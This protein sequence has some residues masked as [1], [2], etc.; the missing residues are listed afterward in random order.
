[1]NVNPVCASSRAAATSP[2]SRD[3]AESS[4]NHDH[5][6]L[7]FFFRE[8]VKKL[9]NSYDGTVHYLPLTRICSL[10]CFISESCETIKKIWPIDPH[11]DEDFERLNHVNS[12][13]VELYDQY[14][15]QDKND[16][17]IFV[18]IR[19]K[20]EGDLLLS[21]L[22]L[23]K[24]MQEKL[25]FLCGAFVF[26]SANGRIKSD[27][28][29]EFGLT[30]K[31]MYFFKKILDG[32]DYRSFF[33]LNDQ[34]LVSLKKIDEFLR[35]YLDN[36]NV[37]DNKM[38]RVEC[39]Y[40]N[41]VKL[42]AG[43]GRPDPDKE[44]LIRYGFNSVQITQTLK[45]ITEKHKIFVLCLLL[46]SGGET[47]LKRDLPGEI[48]IHNNN[49]LIVELL[50]KVRVL[51]K[52]IEDARVAKKNQ[53]KKNCFLDQL[54][55]L[56]EKLMAMGAQ[57]DFIV[58]VEDSSFISLM[59]WHME[60]AESFQNGQSQFEQVHQAFVAMQDNI[61]KTADNAASKAARKK[62]Q[63]LEKKP[64]AKRL[65]GVVVEAREDNATPP[66]MRALSPPPPLRAGAPAESKESSAS[67]AT[68]SMP[69]LARPA[70]DYWNP[71]ATYSS[72]A[73]C[74][75]G[76]LA[77]KTVGLTADQ[78]THLGLMLF[79][80]DQVSSVKNQLVWRTDAGQ[81]RRTIEGSGRFADFRGVYTP[82]GH[83]ITIHK[84]RFNTKITSDDYANI[85]KP[86]RVA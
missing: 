46:Q 68:N 41:K 23:P 77:R 27:L 79:D 2:L 58:E 25:K 74:M 66:R 65:G 36:K 20:F 44:T 48:P 10:L 70:A 6:E 34:E 4:Q 24:Y 29:Y 31:Q 7:K 12:K 59:K 54:N 16:R 26:C 3:L 43:H 73:K 17:E 63:S 83:L 76:H 80:H 5:E 69:A 1:M 21:I 40:G 56:D 57:L 18:E 37:V 62:A 33:E 14:K 86:I 11:G 28:T 82:D 19:K 49:E 52:D 30:L 75:S 55:S 32:G 60:H 8:E 47:N 50:D 71:G 84:R 78:Y 15:Y 22:S 85:F 38:I 39:L 42:N 61:T 35:F 13:S 53:S 67:P 9:S 45:P 64:Q 51:K 81:L 72:S